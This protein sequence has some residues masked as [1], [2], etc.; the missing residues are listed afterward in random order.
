MREGENE[1][2]RQSAEGKRDPVTTWPAGRSGAPV[3]DGGAAMP[4]TKDV[5]STWPEIVIVEG[6]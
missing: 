6:A 4:V 2:K 5:A 1:L 3:V